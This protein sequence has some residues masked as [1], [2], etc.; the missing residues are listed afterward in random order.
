MEG[1]KTFT[2][3]LR[4]DDPQVIV[5]FSTAS[6]VIEITGTDGKDRLNGVCTAHAAIYCMA[7]SWC[8]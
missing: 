4:I 8:T 2:V 1:T 6:A 5:G 3:F 7:K